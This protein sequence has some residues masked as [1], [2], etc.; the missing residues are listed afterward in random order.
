MT[1][2]GGLVIIAPSWA[3]CRLLQPDPS[4]WQPGFC[5][6]A[7]AAAPG[8]PGR[9][10]AGRAG[11]PPPPAEKIGP[12]MASSLDCDATRAVIDW[13]GGRPV[14][15]PGRHAAL[16][17]HCARSRSSYATTNRRAVTSCGSLRWSVSSAAVHDDPH[18]SAVG[19]CYR[20]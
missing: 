9:R 2:G 16:R 20:R 7:A 17:R 5:G 15:Q 12:V 11:P 8:G 4:L 13:R 14:D 19:R 6:T 10:A 1:A 3:P 18:R